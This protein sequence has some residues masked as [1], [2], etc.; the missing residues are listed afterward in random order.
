LQFIVIDGLDAS[1][2]DTQALRL[3]SFLRNNRK[4]VCLRI[5]PAGDNFFG[6]NAKRFL[7]SKGKSAHFASAMF[8]MMDVIRSIL[9][10]AWRKYDYIVFV[11]YL[12][13]TAY[14]PSTIHKIAYW[15]FACIVPKSNTMFFLDITPEEACRRI[16]LRHE[17]HE[18][19][20]DFG[21]LRKVRAKALFLALA[22]KWVIINA[23][24]SAEQVELEIRR[25]LFAN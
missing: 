1:G 4:A 16:R 18:M 15:F 5:H 24:Q 21:E 23:D 11:R 22:D 8:Y 12:M 19:F 2:K 7:L 14:L 17:T 10:Y 13:G 25:H 6:V 20:E 9:Y 3:C